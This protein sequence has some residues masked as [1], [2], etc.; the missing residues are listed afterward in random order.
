MRKL[1]L[2]QLQRPDLETYRRQP[3]LPVEVVLDQLRS[4][5]NV[6]SFFRTC[7]AFSIQRIHLCGYTPRPGH[8]SLEKVAL[9]ATQSVL[10]DEYAETSACLRDLRQRGMRIFGLEQTDEALSMADFQMARHTPLA[11]VFGNEVDGIQDHLLDMLDGAL[12]VPQRGTKHSLNVSVC[13]GAVLWEV[14]RQLTSQP[15]SKYLK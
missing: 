3:K 9:G 12:E 2:E 10:W 14:F 5:H 7:D 1:K 15:D 13:G 8:R 11:L 4:A 6:G